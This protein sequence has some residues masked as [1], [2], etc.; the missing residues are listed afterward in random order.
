MKAH[1]LAKRLLE[2]PEDTIIIYQGKDL[3]DTQVQNIA[4]FKNA[5]ENSINREET[6]KMIDAGLYPSTY[7]VLNPNPIFIDND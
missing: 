4:V 7:V 5:T 1:E 3:D 2:L 6:L